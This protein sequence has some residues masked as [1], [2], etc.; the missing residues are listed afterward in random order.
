MTHPL[1]LR[2]PRTLD[3]DLVA[4]LQRDLGS[5]TLFFICAIEAAL[6]VQFDHAE[7]DD[8]S[9]DPEGENEQ[10]EVELLEE[11]A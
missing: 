7:F 10:L 4:D 5:D 8:V 9:A 6:G 1:P 2:S 11:A 3:P